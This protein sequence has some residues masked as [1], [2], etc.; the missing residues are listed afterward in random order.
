MATRQLLASLSD[1]DAFITNDLFGGFEE[2]NGG[3][4]HHCIVSHKNGFSRDGRGVHQHEKAPNIPA[5]SCYSQGERR[6][7]G[8]RAWRV[9]GRE[10]SRGGMIQ[11]GEGGESVVRNP[12]RPPAPTSWPIAALRRR[13]RRKIREHASNR[14]TNECVLSMC[15]HCLCHSCLS[16]LR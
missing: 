1:T 6:R 8:L 13:T 16:I 4:E 9:P 2:G 12:G 7:G 3:S 10:G 14:R 11:S 15:R 5:L